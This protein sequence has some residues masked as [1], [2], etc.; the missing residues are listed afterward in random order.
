MEPT[1]EKEDLILALI[2]ICRKYHNF[3]RSKIEDI[4]TRY[5]IE[6]KAQ[7]NK[8]ELDKLIFFAKEIIDE[9]MDKTI[10]NPSKYDKEH[11]EQYFVPLINTLNTP[12]SCQNT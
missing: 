8:A 7:M 9:F 5:K 12:T 4:F 10:A 3:R 11:W 2:P 6:N 1:I